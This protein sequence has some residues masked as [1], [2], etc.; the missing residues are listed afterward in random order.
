LLAAYAFAF[1]WR[2]LG[3][4]LLIVDDHPGQLYR[5]ARVV[6]L[7]PWPWRLDPGWWAGYAELQY[8]P[9]GAAYVGAV[10]QV[11][12]LGALGSEAVYQTLLWVIYVLPGAT[13]YLLLVRILG[14]PWL[15]LPGAFLALT[16][17]G[18]S[19]SGV[20]EGLRWGL[21]AA[22]LG[23][24]LLPLLALSLRPWT[25]RAKLPLPAPLIFAS[26]IL[27]HPAH[28]PAGLVLVFL[29]AAEGPGGLRSRMTSAGLLTFAAA[30]L[31][32]FWLV[33]LLSHLDMALP[34]AWGD[35][36][37]GALAAQIVTRPLLLGLSVA[38]TLACWMTRV[39]ASPAARDRWLARFAP[40]LAAVI[41]LDAV[42]LQPL[43]LMWLPA[44]RLMDS[45]LLALILGASRALGEVAPRL[46]RYPDWGIALAAIAGCALLASPDRSE[47]TLTL[48]PRRGPSEWTQEATL[49]AGARLDD[50][51]ALLRNAPPGRILFVRSSVPLAY[52]HRQ[53][54]R[55]H[56][57][58]TALAPIR[59]GREIVNGTFTHPSPIAGLVYTGT[60]ANR[61]ITLLVEQ[62]DGLTLFG[63]PLEALTPA[64]FDRLAGRL[65]ISAVV[66]LDED[67][68]RL[69]FLDD[70]P[71]FA[72]PSRV[73]PFVIYASREPRP[74]PVLV[75]PQRWQF[76]ATESSG[77]W[78]STGFAYS[79]LWRARAGDQRLAARRDDLGMLE[80]NLPAGPST[81]VEL[82]HAPGL[83]EWI[84]LAVT[85]LTGLLLV[86][87]AAARITPA[88]RS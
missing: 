58:I 15:A 76:R 48:W 25:E 42:V 11:F 26:L 66:A 62:R 8:Y 41:L 34:L 23:W 61:P 33:P 59:T 24:S 38:S 84:G 1:A 75:A 87:R 51:W 17:S 3:G 35:S 86:A 19:R 27:I 29:C 50:L 10:L 5:L 18:G 21:I 16:L 44:D 74:I 31:A 22:R 2:A 28:A 68:G 13:T 85:V 79:P 77:G 88:G 73:G 63:R 53:W 14:R 9:P 30:G 6:E 40:A 70:N 12:S 55:P 56:S 64:E 20:E 43:G 57:H 36:S 45:L 65:R 80:V 82:S 54:W 78:A 72:R 60:A 39:G 81:S 69:P 83:A 52:G 47:P 32:G 67:E 71:A 7:G 49:V 46:Q 37:L 4:G